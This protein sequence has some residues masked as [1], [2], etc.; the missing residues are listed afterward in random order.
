MN[1]RKFELEIDSLPAPSKL[2]EDKIAVRVSRY[3][4]TRAKVGNWWI[5]KNVLWIPPPGSATSDSSMLTQ[6]V[7]SGST[8]TSSITSI[9][10]ET[11]EE[12]EPGEELQENEKLSPD[13]F[14]L[15]SEI[16]SQ[17]KLS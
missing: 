14:W 10:I 16:G 11:L 4:A 6:N 13:M 5:M 2:A 12:T 8:T 1:E 9:N 15:L 3:S 17:F 7:C